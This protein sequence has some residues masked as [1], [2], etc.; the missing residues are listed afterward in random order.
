[1]ALLDADP[2]PLEQ[3]V[4]GLLNNA[5]EASHR[6]GVVTLS[7]TAEAGGVCLGIA[8]EAGGLPF[9]PE[10]AG[11]VPGPTTKRFGTGLGIPIAYKICQTHGYRLEF[12]TRPEGGT[13]VTI[14]APAYSEHAALEYE[15]AD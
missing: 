15:R 1:M 5:L 13:R 7:V 14:K 9:T 6:G 12:A 8:D 3:A 2:D 10:P 4:Y 11:L